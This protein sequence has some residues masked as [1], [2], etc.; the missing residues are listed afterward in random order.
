MLLF[1]ADYPDEV[2]LLEG[3]AQRVVAIDKLYRTEKR[4]YLFVSYRKFFK[5]QILPIDDLATHYRCNLFLHFF[6]IL[7]LFRQSWL[8]YFHSIMNVLPVLPF[9]IFI[10][11]GQR[12]V[13]DAHGLV[14]E[15][16]YLAGTRWKSSLYELS[17]RRIFKIADVVITVTNA[18]ER[19]YLK[20]HPQATVHYITWTNLPSHLKGV[21]YQPI[22][23]TAGDEIRVVYSGN[24]QMWQNVGLMVEVIKKN[25]SPRIRYDLLTGQPDLMKQYLENAGILGRPNIHV[26]TVA[27]N[28][29]ESYYKAAHYG[30]MMRGDEDV[31]RVS[32]PTKVIEY[33][34]YGIVPIMK[35]LRIGDFEEMGC[36][37]VLYD[38]FSEHMGPRKSQNNHRIIDGLLKSEHELFAQLQKVFR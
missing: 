5:R 15:E 8:L 20:K 17:E 9:L 18:M 7:K 19:Y 12:V 22:E 33:M 16:Q 26:T 32:C 23:P 13:L 25:L 24:T 35:T 36:E 34:Y 14:A 21:N 6:F 3:M 2:T 10:R 37:C 31:S 4:I 11:K 29:L 1:L 38:Q 30:F 28:D 27:P